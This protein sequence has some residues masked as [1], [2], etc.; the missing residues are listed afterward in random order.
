MLVGKMDY[1]RISTQGSIDKITLPKTIT[2]AIYTTDN[3]E[4]GP[5]LD[6]FINS[7]KH[8]I[9]DISDLNMNADGSLILQPLTVLFNGQKLFD[10]NGIEAKTVD[11]N[12]N[13]LGGATADHN[14]DNVYSKLDHIHSEYSPLVHTHSISDITD[15]TGGGLTELEP[16]TIYLNG[17]E[18]INYNGT[19]P[20]SLDITPIELGCAPLDH[21]HT[22]NS[23]TNF[24]LPDF[25]ITCIRYN[26]ETEEE[27]EVPFSYNGT[28]PITLELD[29]EMVGAAA[30][31][32]RH[33]GYAV[34]DHNHD[35]LYSNI[36]HVHE[37]IYS[38]A[39][40]IKNGFTPNSILQL[41]GKE[42]TGEANVRVGN[43][44][45]SLAGSSDAKGE[46]SLAAGYGSSA[47]ANNSIALGYLAISDV[48]NGVA[49]GTRNK[50]MGEGDILSVGCG[51]H[52][53]GGEVRANC[54][55]I[56]ATDVYGGTYNST[57]ADYA[58]YFEWDDEN[59][60]NEDRI[61]LFVT[62]KN[63]KITVA[64]CKDSFI[65]GVIS[66]GSSIIGNSHEEQWKNTYKKDIYGRVI[67]DENNNPVLNPEYNRD[68]VYIPRSKRKEWDVVGMLGVLIVRDDGT[69]IPNKSC[70]VIDGG[71]ASLSSVGGFRVLERLSDN[72][73]KILFRG[74]CSMV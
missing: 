27:L 4:N 15:F 39:T 64:D 47:Q 19:A 37:G 7:H 28:E 17:F 26:E 45:A 72:V 55:R 8:T 22:F 68:N 13:T 60:N 46:Y 25:H 12:I 38:E 50:L 52:T 34:V 18:K 5:T 2:K 16:F 9:A 57:G 36:N 63:N 11:F 32:H 48:D 58:E 31:Y 14:H 51:T 40:N 44:S 24:S 43:S 3:I 73:I 62:L 67:V 54:L 6:S 42:Y 61:G 20:M 59:I 65:C 29:Y 23:I 49:L 21:T 35:T 1:L 70:R 71:I 33:T 41:G 10:Y 74:E 69:C 66:S 30:K 53:E 56:T